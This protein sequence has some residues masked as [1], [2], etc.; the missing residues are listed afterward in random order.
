MKPV[1][2]ALVSPRRWY[3][4]LL[5]LPLRLIP[6]NSVMPIFQAVLKGRRWIVGSSVHSCWLGSYKTERSAF[7]RKTLVP[8]STFFDSGAQAGYY[9]LL[10]ARGVGAAGQI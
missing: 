10:A 4:K 5:G 9:T 2:F 7:V 8:G 3:G 1:D 6:P